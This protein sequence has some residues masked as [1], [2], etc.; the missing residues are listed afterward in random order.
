MQT[1][2]VPH[3]VFIYKFI[4]PPPLVGGALIVLLY[5]DYC[6]WKPTRFPVL[7]LFTILFLFY[8]DYYLLEA[9]QG[10]KHL[11]PLN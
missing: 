3:N 11:N 7:Y 6:L 2:E 9:S 10:L 1:S 5:D 8:H 4:F